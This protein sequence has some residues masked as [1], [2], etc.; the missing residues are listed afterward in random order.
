MSTT[1]QT[2]RSLR[3]STAI[4]RRV[5]S[6]PRRG[7]ERTIAAAL[8]GEGAR[9]VLVDI[10]GDAANRTTD[11]L[12][13]QGHEV[14][15]IQ[16]DVAK[17]EDIDRT[18]VSAIKA[19]GSEILANHA[20]F[21]SF[22]T[23]TETDN[24]HWRKMIDLSLTA[25]FLMSRRLLPKMVE[26]KRGVIINTIS[27]AVYTAAKHGPV[28]LTKSIATVYGAN[29]IRCIG[30]G[31]G[32]VRSLLPDRMKPQI[33]PSDSAEGASLER[34]PALGNRQGVPRLP[35]LSRSLSPTRQAL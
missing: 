26:K 32:Y 1:E 20:G 35:M 6:L 22:M 14:L 21:G 4:M 17:A 13:S 19:F 11:E 3:G 30:I 2:I 18:A 25:P 7:I 28:G 15:T 5:A 23:V 29:R 34:I 12:L 33:S 24:D 27:S 16:A 10:G 8:A 9:I 31:L